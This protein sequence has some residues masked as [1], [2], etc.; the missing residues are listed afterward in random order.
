MNLTL[1]RRAIRHALATIDW[2]QARRRFV[3]DVMHS[4]L[5]DQ[6]QTRAATF[7]NARPKPGDYLGRA[8]PAQIA[9]QDRRCARLAAACRLHAAL[10]RGDDLLDTR[11]AADVALYV[12]EGW[13]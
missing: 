13:R 6:W 12:S 5:P 8:T 2:E 7:D 4:A 1:D 10:L 3:L 11:H 9:A